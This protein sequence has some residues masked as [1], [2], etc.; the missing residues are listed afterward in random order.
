VSRGDQTRPARVRVS[1]TW[2]PPGG[3]QTDPSPR[4]ARVDLCDPA[5][6]IP[7]CGAPTPPQP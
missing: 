2:G 3:A 4:I 5:A 7:E 1:V 6:T